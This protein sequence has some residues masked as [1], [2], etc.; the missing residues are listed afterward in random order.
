MDKSEASGFVIWLTGLPG[1]GK[2]TTA[3]LLENALKARGL[4]VETLDGD[5]VR[6]NMSPDL[7]FSK[8]DRE[9]HAMRVAYVSHLLSRNGVVTIVA[10]IS[11]F[12]SFRDYARKLI[13]GFVEV[14]VNCSVETCRMRD[15]K[16]LYRMAADGKMSNL[17]GI[18]DPYE[19][20]INPEIII[21]TEAE[22][23]DACLNKIMMSLKSLNYIE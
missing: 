15:P 6:K 9:M 17:T 18:Q 14:W 12:R 2:T 13:K 10:L 1:S 4:R 5:E 11:P 7:G 3:R 20:P 21:D 22:S 16:G 23:P 8:S 19:P